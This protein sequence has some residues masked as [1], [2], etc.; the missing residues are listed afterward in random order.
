LGQSFNCTDEQLQGLKSWIDY[1]TELIAVQRQLSILIRRD[2]TS[3]HRLDY[4]TW[5]DRRFN[6]SHP[7]NAALRQYLGDEVSI[8]GVACR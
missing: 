1:E 6:C 2:D 7:D 3:N 5:L 8:S 4:L